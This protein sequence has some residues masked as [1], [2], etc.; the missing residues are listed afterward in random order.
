MGNGFVLSNAIHLVGHNILF[1]RRSESGR[2]TFSQ[3]RGRISSKQKFSVVDLWIR[4][5]SSGL[6]GGLRR[7]SEWHGL[8]TRMIIDVHTLD[9]L[10]GIEWQTIMTLFTCK[11]SYLCVEL[12][13]PNQNFNMCSASGRSCLLPRLVRDSQTCRSSRRTPINMP[14]FVSSLL[15]NRSKLI[16]RTC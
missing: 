1:L 3:S 5:L 14:I 15:I 12:E 10:L 13:C 7:A 6:D 2:V 9:I 16:F 11:L 8:N 4:R